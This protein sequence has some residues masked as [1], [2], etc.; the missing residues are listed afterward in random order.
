MQDRSFC[1]QIVSSIEA[2]HQLE[3]RSRST[4]LRCSECELE[5]FGGICLPP[6][7]LEQGVLNKALTIPYRAD[8]TFCRI[9][10]IRN[11]YSQCIHTS[12]G[13]SCLLQRYETEG[14][15]KDV[16]NLLVAATR[17][18]TSKTHESSWRRWCRWCNIKKV[19]PLAATLSNIPSFLGDCFK[20]GLQYR[21]INVLRSGSFL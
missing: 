17:T 14:L 18:S 1:H 4:Q 5:R 15:S 13:H 21:T 8:H 2:I 19:N 9:Q 12:P 11:R 10:Q 16:A 6:F 3:T 20:E 7:N